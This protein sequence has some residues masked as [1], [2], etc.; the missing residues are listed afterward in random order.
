MQE[1]RLDPTD[2]FELFEQL[3]RFYK[4]TAQT[5]GTVPLESFFY[6]S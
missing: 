6:N 3:E 2:K 1:T 5:V 4:L